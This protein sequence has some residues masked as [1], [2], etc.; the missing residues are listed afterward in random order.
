MTTKELRKK[1]LEANYPPT[2]N[3]DAETYAIACQEVF[4][5]SCRPD[6]WDLIVSKE[7]YSFRIAIGKTNWGLMFKN[8]ELI[9]DLS[10]RQ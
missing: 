7:G 9:L 2:F 10:N 8:V 1:L 3:V 6:N 4:T 5:W